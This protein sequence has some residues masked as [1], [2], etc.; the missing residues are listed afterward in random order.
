MSHPTSGGAYVR[1][2]DGTIA[3]VG[4]TSPV[5]VPPAPTVEQAP[6]ARKT[7][8]PADAA[9]GTDTPKE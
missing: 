5:T 6:K 3:P 1:L 2:P 4:D 9:V 8:A 7:A